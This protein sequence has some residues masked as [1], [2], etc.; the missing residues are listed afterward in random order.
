MLLQIIIIP[1]ISLLRVCLLAGRDLGREP[2]L[3]DFDPDEQE[4]LEHYSKW[5]PYPNRHGALEAI[6]AD[7]ARGIVEKADPLA[8]QTSDDMSLR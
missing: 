2:V 5:T 4:Q 7:T 3:S 8:R 6:V 1:S